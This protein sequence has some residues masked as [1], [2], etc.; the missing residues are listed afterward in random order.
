MSTHKGT[1]VGVFTTPVGSTTLTVVV[2]A[3]RNN[4][5]LHSGGTSGPVPSRLTIA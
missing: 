3:M 2:F 5:G 1:V 4:G